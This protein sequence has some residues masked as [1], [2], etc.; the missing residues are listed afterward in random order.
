MSVKRIPPLAAMMSRIRMDLFM[1]QLYL[2]RE[3][4]ALGLREPEMTRGHPILGLVVD[5]EH[6]GVV[7][8]TKTV[9]DSLDETD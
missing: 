7:S 3:F 8:L 2:M 5:S 6:V 9:D 1:R 4:V